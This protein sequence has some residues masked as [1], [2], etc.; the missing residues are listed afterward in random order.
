[1]ST[2]TVMKA[3]VVDSHNAAF[4]LAE[5]PQPSP[6]TGEVLVRIKASG[7]NPLDT[8]I[9]AG[10]AG[11]A[12]HPLP[13]ILGIDLAGIVEAIGDGVSGFRVGDE[14]YGMTGGVGGIQ[15]SLA[16]Y[17]AVDARLLAVKPGNLSM[18]EAAALPLIFITAWEGLVDRAHVQ[19]G[20]KVLVIGAGGVGHIVIQIAKA[21]G[22]DVY[23][24][25][26]ASKADDIRS[27][28]ATPIDRNESIES[29]VKAHTGGKGFDLVY[30]TVGGAGLDAAF[31][32]VG[33]FGHVVSC[34]GWGTH[35][36]AP[37]S[38]KA[39]TYSGVF[40]LLPLLSGEGRAHHGE[41]MAEATKLAEAGRL[42]PKLDS[43]RFTFANAGD[44]HAL[45][46][47]RGADGKLVVEVD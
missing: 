16:Q 25:D 18:R 27:L 47:S 6:A 4:R 23:A 32:A 22:A 34:L 15:G 40:T 43:R 19:A 7:V 38:F 42:A 41:I 3:L 46:E 37:L 39:A 9:R 14:V 30:D 35:A 11:H 36:L 5:V 17:A 44:A 28:S 20:Q 33:R 10:A 1:M 31:Q 2:S 45:I 24:V 21:S 29:Y 13:A 12:R 8:K 26:S